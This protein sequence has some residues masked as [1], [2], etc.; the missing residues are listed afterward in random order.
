MEGGV[1]L[2]AGTPAEAFSRSAISNKYALMNSE[3]CSGKPGRDE[4]GL[5]LQARLAHRMRQLRS[6]RRSLALLRYILAETSVTIAMP[7]RHRSIVFELYSAL[8]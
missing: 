6:S 8:D 1:R 3:F 7:C 4:S 5:D 2:A